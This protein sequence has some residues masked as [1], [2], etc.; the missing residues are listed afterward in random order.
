MDYKDIAIRVA[1]TFVQAFGG[2]FIPVLVVYLQDGLPADFNTA[3]IALAPTIAA[4]LAAAISA[5]W[6]YILQYLDVYSREV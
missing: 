4:A 2:V 3:W 6:N 1:K 5:V